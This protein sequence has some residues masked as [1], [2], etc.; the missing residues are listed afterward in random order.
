MPCLMF[1]L[2]GICFIIINHHKQQKHSKN[3]TISI[4]ILLII[5]KYLKI[6]RYIYIYILINYIN[7]IIITIVVSSDPPQESRLLS[8]K[9]ESVTRPIPSLLLK[10]LSR[11]CP[12]LLLAEKS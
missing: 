8:H 7:Y 1:G 10:R 6:Y 2:P 4:T 5:I 11:S 12:G 9:Q 3:I